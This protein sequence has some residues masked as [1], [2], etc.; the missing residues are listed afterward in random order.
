MADYDIKQNSSDVISH[1]SLTGTTQKM[2]LTTDNKLV[3]ETTYEVDAVAEMAKAER[4]SISRTD[5][6]ADGM[7]KVAS[8]PMMVYLDLR[9]R[10]ILGDKTALRKWLASDEAAPFR[11][12]WIAS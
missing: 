2:H 7:V 12:H 5:K 8:I 3:L 6:V 11:T 1:D 9:K 10:G 4:N